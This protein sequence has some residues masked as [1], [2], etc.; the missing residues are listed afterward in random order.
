MH[1]MG[2]VCSSSYRAIV[3]AGSAPWKSKCVFRNEP[4][5]RVGHVTKTLDE[6]TAGFAN[7][8]RI[9]LAGKAG[10]ERM[11]GAG[12]SPN[13]NLGSHNLVSRICGRKATFPSNRRL[14]HACSSVDHTG[15]FATLATAAVVVLRNSS[16]VWACRHGRVERELRLTRF[17]MLWPDREFIIEISPPDT[18]STPLAVFDVTF[19]RNFTQAHGFNRSHDGYH[20][21]SG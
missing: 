1:K 17:I 13:T 11:R 4:Q 14:W 16:R 18:R 10:K 2:C 8:T 9:E 5:S 15:T 6:C 12:R 3:V 21:R 19:L 7:R 20:R